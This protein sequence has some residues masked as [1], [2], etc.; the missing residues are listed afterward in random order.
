MHRDGGEQPTS[1]VSSLD[2]RAAVW[3]LG[4]MLPLVR[5]SRGRTVDSVHWT[6]RGGEEAGGSDWT[7][8]LR[9]AVNDPSVGRHQIGRRHGAMV[10][11]G[12]TALGRVQCSA[13]Q[14]SAVQCSAVQCSTV[15]CSAAQC[16]A[17]QCITVQ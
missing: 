13:V 15:Q 9:P 6:P 4:G 8:D 12:D 7:S 11:K 10:H 14:C 5:H 3:G 17:V 2:N 1:S 16:S